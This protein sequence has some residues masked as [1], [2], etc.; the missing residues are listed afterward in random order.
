[1]TI[2]VPW[3]TDHIQRLLTRKTSLARG[4]TLELQVFK[5][6]PVFSMQDFNGHTALDIAAE[7]DDLHSIEVLLGQSATLE[8]STDPTKTLLSVAVKNGQVNLTKQLLKLSHSPYCHPPLPTHLLESHSASTLDLPPQ[9]HIKTLPRWNFIFEAT[10]HAIHGRLNLKELEKFL[11]LCE[12]LDISII[13]TE[14]G[15]I[16]PQNF[17]HEDCLWNGWLPI[18]YVI[19]C[20]NMG[21]LRTF[22]SAN[23]W[24]Q[25]DMTKSMSKTRVEMMS[26]DRDVRWHMAAWSTVFDYS[27][28]F[29]LNNPEA[30]E[31]VIVPALAE[32]ECEEQFPKVIPVV[33]N[34]EARPATSVQQVPVTPATLKE[35]FKYRYYASLCTP[36]DMPIEIDSY[37][38]HKMIWSEKSCLTMAGDLRQWTAFVKVPGRAESEYV[39]LAQR[40]DVIKLLQPVP[41]T[42]A[43]D[44]LWSRLIREVM[45]ETRSRTEETKKMFL[46]KVEEDSRRSCGESNASTIVPEPW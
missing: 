17:W 30:I 13:I 42:A 41:D 20:G 15:P 12:D 1:M 44:E 23:V 40:A 7:Q 22:I 5:W 36:S 39:P 31:P 6:E 25:Q 29:D 10:F 4:R 46:G 34:F 2:R 37:N 33:S 18:H 21:V 32:P 38:L 35:P 43:L 16:S 14:N 26:E 9:T 27:T 8:G 19:Y 45:D 3:T 11:G 24:S 28:L